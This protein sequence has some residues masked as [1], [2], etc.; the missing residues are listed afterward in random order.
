V[1]ISEFLIAEGIE[2]P[3][4]AEVVRAMGCEE[5]QGFL[6]AKPMPTQ[7]LLEFLKAN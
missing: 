1:R 2:S 4:Q 5:V 3:E 6:Y 7:A